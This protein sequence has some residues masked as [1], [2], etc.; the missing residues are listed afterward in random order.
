MKRAVA[1]FFLVVFSFS[2]PGYSIEVHFCKGKLTDISFFGDTSC[3]CEV[4]L[5]SNV[6]STSEDSCHRNCHA[7]KKQVPDSATK[8]QQKKCCSTEKL[9][10]TSSKLKAFS[11]VPSSSAVVLAVAVLN[12][13]IL[14]TISGVS[15]PS[16]EFYTPPAFERDLVLI[17]RTL[18]I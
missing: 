14:Q 9:T 12:P 5:E 17:H 13:F 7:L 4:P 18:L 2:L 8:I 6:I 16:L 11:P 1:L 15:K 3:K 10:L